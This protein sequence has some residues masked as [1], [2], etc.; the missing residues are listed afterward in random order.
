MKSFYMNGYLW[1][2]DFVDP[3]DETLIDRTGQ[4]RLATTDPQS[5]MIFVT[6]E[7]SGEMLN[8]VLI[9]ELGHCVLISFDLLRDIQRMVKKEYWFEAEEWVCNLLADYGS[10]IFD[11]L[12]EILGDDPLIFVP[13]ELE[14]LVA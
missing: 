4:Y 12:H 9:H 7:L 14:R 5:F 1:Y 8:K 11:S 2:V 13:Y 3:D 10:T 6:N